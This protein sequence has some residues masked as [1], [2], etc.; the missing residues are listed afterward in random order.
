MNKKEGRKSRDTVPFTQH[1][2]V[3]SLRPQ[4]NVRITTEFCAESQGPQC[5]LIFFFVTG[6]RF[7]AI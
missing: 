7:A 6:I 3:Y 1:M 4:A 2:D 5:V